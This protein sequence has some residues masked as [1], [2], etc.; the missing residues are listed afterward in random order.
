M[1]IFKKNQNIVNQ[2]RLS[3]KMFSFTIFNSLDRFKFG[4]ALY[5]RVKGVQPSP[6]Y[7]VDGVKGVQPSPL[8]TV[9]GVKGVQPSPLYTVDGVKGVQPSPLYTVDGVKPSH[10]SLMVLKGSRHPIQR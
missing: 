10:L 1:S 4:L 7:T 9:D 3:E 5:C 6:L 2:V 8:Y